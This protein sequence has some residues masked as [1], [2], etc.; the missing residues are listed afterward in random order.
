MSTDTIT[1]ARINQ[2]RR[3][4]AEAK[5]LDE[6][7][8]VRDMAEAARLYARAAGLGQDAMNEAAEIKLRA[9]RKAGE[10]LAAMDKN[11][12]GGFTH[13]KPTDSQAESVTEHP[14]TL[15]DLDITPKQ[16]MNWQAEATVPEPIFEAHIQTAKQNGDPLTTS[17]V[18]RLA[19]EAQ[20]KRE[21][22]ETQAVIEAAG[23]DD[24][25]LERAR[26][27]AAY[28]KAIHQAGDLV[29]LN[30]EAVADTLTE[31]D[32]RLAQM[33]VERLSAWL[34]RFER[35]LTRGIHLIEGGISHG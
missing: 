26:L 6:I 29:A 1:I 20:A 12:G 7:K 9:E 10:A 28:S 22:E 14:P 18:V 33:N 34:T 5:G 32:R 31:D 23:D 11:R 2:A 16:S 30:A 21:I 8:A 35:A 25:R 3:L 13:G 4:L 24:G 17:G 15:A 27:K 19:R